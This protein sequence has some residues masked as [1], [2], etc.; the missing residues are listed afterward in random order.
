MLLLWLLET[1]QDGV[2]FALKPC[3]CLLLLYHNYPKNP[4]YTR[5][6]KSFTQKEGFVN[7]FAR[8]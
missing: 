8:I 6:K 4:R 5:L 1:W 7:W 3:L 2:R